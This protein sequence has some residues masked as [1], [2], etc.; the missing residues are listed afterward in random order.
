MKTLKPIH[1]FILTF[2]IICLWGCLYMLFAFVKADA[3]PFNWSEDARIF[4][5]FLGVAA[6]FVSIGVMVNLMID[7]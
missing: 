6:T 5:A 1:L 4:L 2:V 3:N 7:L